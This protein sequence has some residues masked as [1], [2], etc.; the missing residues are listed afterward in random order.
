MGKKIGRENDN[1]RTI[2]INL[3]IALEDIVTATA[4]Y[5][6]AVENNIGTEL[7]L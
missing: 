2:C 6:K 5:K 7:S 1:E 3:G 4:I